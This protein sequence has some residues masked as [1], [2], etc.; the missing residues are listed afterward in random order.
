MILTE[1]RRAAGNLSV[2]LSTMTLCCESC[3]HVLC[4]GADVEDPRSCER[5]NTRVVDSE[6]YD[7]DFHGPAHG[8]SAEANAWDGS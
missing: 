5:G 7:L 1:G 2:L 4:K 6:A 3:F 8:K